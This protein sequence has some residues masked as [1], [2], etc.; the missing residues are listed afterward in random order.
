MTALPARPQRDAAGEPAVV[1]SPA[2]LA[3]A[4]DDAVAFG[5]GIERRRRSHL[6]RELAAVLDRIDHDHLAGARHAPGLHRA[7][8]DRPGAEHDDVG[9]GLESACRRDR[10]QSPT[11]A[12]RRAA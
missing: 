1:R 8:A 11:P 6:Q 7:E 12:D 3:H 10:R 4:L 2:Q 9:S 5:H